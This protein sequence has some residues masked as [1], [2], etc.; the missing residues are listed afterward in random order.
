MLRNA[1]GALIAGTL[2]LMP[3]VGQAATPKPKQKEPVVNPKPTGAPKKVSPYATLNRRRLEAG[4]KEPEH[5]KKGK[6]PTR[7][8][9]VTVRKH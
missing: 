3:A 7:L 1:L 4:E 8:H 6:P 5:S 9:P 2:L